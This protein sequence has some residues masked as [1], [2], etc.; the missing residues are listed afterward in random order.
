MS[1]ILELEIRDLFPDKKPVYPRRKLGE[2]EVP[3]DVELE[4]GE[5]VSAPGSHYSF[6][7]VLEDGQLELVTC[8]SVPN[9]SKLR[10]SESTFDRLK[11]RKV[12]ALR[13]YG[14]E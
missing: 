6:Y 13:L 10:V 14:G 8:V 7:S 4:V 5:T 12:I 2:T 1:E 3:L 9:P 11:G